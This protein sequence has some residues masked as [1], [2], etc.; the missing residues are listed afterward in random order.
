MMKILLASANPDKRAE[1]ETLLEGLPVEIVSLAD[2]PDAPRVVEDRETFEGNAAKKASEFAQFTGLHAV[3]DDSGL[4]VDVLDGAPGV[5][6]ARFAGRKGNYRDVCKKLMSLMRYVPDGQ[7]GARFECHIAFS[8]PDGDILLRASGTCEGIITRQMRGGKGFGY[9]PVFLYPSA[10]K[11]FAQM[12]P[13]EKN[14]F[15]HRA[16]AIEAFR[17]ALAEFLERQG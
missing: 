3:A 6:S 11:T 16:R 14:K 8:D 13:E 9:D 17:P 7:R 4:C 10:G 2:Y 5:M 1:M 12:L 15:S